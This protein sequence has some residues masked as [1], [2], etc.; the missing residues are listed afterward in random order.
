MQQSTRPPP[1]VSLGCVVQCIC[2]LLKHVHIL[3][4]GIFRLAYSEVY[5]V[6]PKGPDLGVFTHSE[7]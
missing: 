1:Q 4:D 6:Q 2:T 7:I 5:N 3:T